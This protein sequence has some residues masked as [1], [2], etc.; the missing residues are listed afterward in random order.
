MEKNTC[1]QVSE[2][3]KKGLLLE[4]SLYIIPFGI[5]KMSDVSSFFTLARFVH[6]SFSSS[7]T[8]E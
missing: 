7:F 4:G 1:F 2:V 6:L 5:S 3:Q 8:K